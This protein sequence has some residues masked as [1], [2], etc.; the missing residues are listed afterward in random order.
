MKRS[1]RVALVLMGAGALSLAACGEKETEVG[2]FESLDQCLD[3]PGMT[4]DQCADALSAARAQ[5]AQVAPKYT[6]TADCEADFGAGQCEQAP[7]QT[8]SGGSVFMPLMMGFMMGQMMGRMG[9]PLYRSADDRGTWRTADN[10]T[11]GR[12]T[13]V[14][15]APASVTRTPSVKTSTV[16]R[17]GFGT[18]APQMAR[19]PTRS[20]GG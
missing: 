17:G 1:R 12:G 4:R 13:G 8:T 2:V 10:R 6:S 14:M 9:Q 16:S 18:R 5:H 11:V 20:F 19:T 7:Y 15:R 3:T